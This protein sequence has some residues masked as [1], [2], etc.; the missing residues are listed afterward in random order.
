MPSSASTANLLIDGYNIIG[1]WP[2]LR[3][4]RDRHSLET[5]RHH[6]VEV[7]SNYAAI[8]G[9]EAEVVF[10]AQYS[11]SRAIR[12]PITDYLWICYT[13]HN[14]TA[15]TYIE[16]TCAHFHSQVKSRNRRLIVA[17][18]DRAQ[19]LTVTGYGAEWMSAHQLLADVEFSQQ[20]MKHK[21]KTTKK[22]PRKLLSNT[23]DPIV[24]QRLAQMR[25]GLP[26]Q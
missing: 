10:D 22:P 6:L 18:S 12:E 16:K 25:F 2:C 23:I 11:R 21:L 8:Q 5:A 9:Y 3:D 24:Q 20:T 15:D 14:Q 17:T 4:V 1:A 13:E 7:L 26:D 19:Q